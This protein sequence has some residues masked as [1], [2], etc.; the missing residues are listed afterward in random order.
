MEYKKAQY[1][2]WFL[3]HLS[4]LIIDYLVGIKGD[5]IESGVLGGARHKACVCSTIGSCSQTTTF[6]WGKK[7]LRIPWLESNPSY[8]VFV[9]SQ[10]D[11]LSLTTPRK[12]QKTRTKSFYTFCWLLDSHLW[13]AP[14]KTIT[15]VTS[16]LECRLKGRNSS[17]SDQKRVDRIFY[18][19]RNFRMEG[20]ILLFS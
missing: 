12:G 3:L 16:P 17:S 19:S 10:L 11:S 2:E 8:W 9:H 15:L 14:P 18:L 20:E 4:F 6:C 5:I 7:L 13:C 1:S